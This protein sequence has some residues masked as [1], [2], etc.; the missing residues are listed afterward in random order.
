MGSEMSGVSIYVPGEPVSKGR[1]RFVRSTGRTYTPAKTATAERSLAQW[2]FEAMAGRPLFNEPLGLCVDLAFAWPKSVTRK[3]RNDPHG[4]WRA[5][6]PDVDNAT[7]LVGDALNNVVWTDDALIVLA[8]VRKFY[9][10]APST[11]I[12]VCPVAEFAYQALLQNLDDL[13]AYRVRVRAAA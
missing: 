10:E 1:P 7:K 9:S 4:M 3:R 12:V 2:A 13:D 8:V 6:R 5:S 11:R